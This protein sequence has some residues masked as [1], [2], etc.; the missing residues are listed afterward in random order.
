VR[1]SFNLFNP[2]GRANFWGRG[3]FSTWAWRWVVPDTWLGAKCFVLG[4][5]FDDGTQ[6]GGRPWC[7]RCS[8]VQKDEP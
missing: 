3:F 6:F 5:D 8:L 2:I 1:Q 4:H 7:Q